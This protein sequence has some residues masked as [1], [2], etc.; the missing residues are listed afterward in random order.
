MRKM[1]HFFFFFFRAA[2]AVHGGSQA[3]D[4]I[5]AVATGL[6]QS[7]SKARSKPRL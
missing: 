4:Q 3:R 2:P 7:Y 6:C 5:G 1:D